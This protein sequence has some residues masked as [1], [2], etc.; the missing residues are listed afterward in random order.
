MLTPQTRWEKFTL[1]NVNEFAEE[2]EQNA[3]TNMDEA[4][5]YLKARGDCF[6]EV[7]D[8]NTINILFA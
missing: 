8:E 2:D 3:V 6:F 5:S 1:R 7:V 4:V